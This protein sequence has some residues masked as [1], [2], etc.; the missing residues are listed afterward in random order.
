MNNKNFQT[1]MAIAIGFLSALILVSTSNAQ[2]IVTTSADETD[3]PANATMASLPGPDGV[4]SL[5]EALRVSDNETGVQT[6]GFQIPE[7]DWYLADIFPGLVLIQ[8][9]FNWIAFEPVVIDGTTQTAF[10]GDTNPEGHEI[11]LYGLEL[12][13]N[14]DGSVISGLDSSHLT[15]SNCQGCTVTG[16]TGDMGIEASTGQSHLISDNEADTIELSY[17]NFNVVVGNT[18]QRVRVSGGGPL[19]GPA[20]GNR[21]GGPNIEDRNFVTGWGNYGEHGFPAGTTIDL[22]GTMDT[23]IENNYIGTTPDGMEIGNAAST[24]GVGVITDNRQ[25]IIRNN[26]LATAATHASGTGDFGSAI[27]ID[28]YEGASDIQIYGNSIGLNA[29]GEP[30]LGGLHGIWI[31]DSIAQYVDNIS[32]GNP[33]LGVGNVIAGHASPGILLEGAP[34]ISPSGGIRFTRNLIYSNGDI[35]IDLMPNTWDFGPTQN[36]SLDSDIGANWLQNYPN[37]N[38][39]NQS[40]QQLHIDGQL[41]SQ[42]S[43]Q[44]T[45]EFFAASSCDPTGVGQAEIYLGSIPVNTDTLGNAQFSTELSQD[46]PANWFVT[47]T[48]TDESTG[49]TSELSLCLQVETS[50]FQLGDVNQDGIVNLLDVAPFV[51][52]MASGTYQTEADMNQD[53]VVNL[54]DVQP[55]VDALAS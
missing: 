54:L 23:I 55:F 51:D 44:Y 48:A 39:A 24:A 3:V 18:A 10:T 13:I 25:V 52:R 37:L 47:A 34:G 14:G 38:S 15:L 30:L 29:N 20:T 27:Y 49:A 46:V 4:V 26:L 7:D 43:R 1:V 50:E 6:I 33:A 35:G 8:G 31:N 42:P 16:N 5:R 12:V 9:S 11:V 17:S 19:F 32:I 28:G 53:G 36:D 45:I 22:F 41:N 2:I 40:G 21:I